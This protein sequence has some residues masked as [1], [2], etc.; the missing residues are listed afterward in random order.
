MAFLIVLIFLYYHSLL[1]HVQSNPLRW[2]NQSKT[3]SIFRKKRGVLFLTFLKMDLHR[4]CF[5]PQWK[6]A[7]VLEGPMTSSRKQKDC[8]SIFSADL[9]D[10]WT[11]GNYQRSNTFNMKSQLEMQMDICGALTPNSE[12]GTDAGGGKWRSGSPLTSQGYTSWDLYGTC[13]GI[14]LP[15]CLLGWFIFSPLSI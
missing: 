1:Y 11:S 4:F 6:E 10:P 13:T 2:I 9:F 8:S 14:I 15:A 12:W 3:S 5:C 7:L